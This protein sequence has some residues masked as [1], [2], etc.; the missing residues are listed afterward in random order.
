IAYTDGSCTNAGYEEAKAGAGIWYGKDDARNKAIR[1]PS[2]LP[3]TNNSAEAA[4]VLIAL[5][6][7]RSRDTLI[8]RTDSKFVIDSVNRNRKKI[9]DSDWL[10]QSNRSLIEPIIARIRHRKGRTAFEKVKGHSGDEGNDGAD[11]LAAIGAEK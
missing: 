7:A 5:Q 6:A 4:A 11:A 9:E 8:I 3:Q 10:E 2:S 1:V